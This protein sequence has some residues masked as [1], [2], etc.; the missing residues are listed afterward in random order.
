MENNLTGYDCNKS[1]IAGID[2]GLVDYSTYAIL[3]PNFDSNSIC[4]SVRDILT[5]VTISR[6]GWGSITGDEYENCFNWT[7]S[8]TQKKL[9]Q[10]VHV[11]YKLKHR[12]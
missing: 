9:L 3:G 5:G 11:R 8:E 6:D 12:Y 1:N 4:D 10:T 7:N 2:I